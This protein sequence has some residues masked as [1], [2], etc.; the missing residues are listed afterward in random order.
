MN[1]T[2]KSLP[3]G[4]FSA[5]VNHSQ[6]LAHDGGLVTQSCPTLA[7]PWTVACQA[8]LSMGFSRPEYW[9]GL[10]CPSPGDL[11]HPGI[12]PRSP[13]LA[14]RFFTIEPPG[15]P[16]IHIYLILSKLINVNK[17]LLLLSTFRI[18]NLNLQRSSPSIT[19]VYLLRNVCTLPPSG[20]SK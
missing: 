14:G 13:A 3:L 7:T 12:K 5:S 16:H 20:G 15:E 8:P 18:K 11:T 4:V 6:F 2:D 1:K 10:L 19:G 17:L 9:S